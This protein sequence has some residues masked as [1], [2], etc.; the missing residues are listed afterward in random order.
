[1][2]IRIV[3][4]FLGVIAFVVSG[5]MIIPFVYSAAAKGRDAGVF[6]VSICAGFAASAALYLGG[7]GA[8]MSKMRTR[9]VMASVSFAWTVSSFI[10]A[11]PYW[12]EGAAP[13]YTDA[14]F[15][16]MS[17]FTT[18]GATIFESLD[19]LPRGLLLWR[20]LTHWLGGMGMIVLTLAL[21][22]VAGVGFQM[23]SAESPGMVH[24][25]IT[26]RLRQTAAALWGIYLGFTA[27]LTLLLYM[28]GFSFFEALNHS[29]ATISTGGFST[30]SSSVAYFGNARAEWMITLFMFMSGA[31]F[32]LYIHA[33]KGR[34][35]KNFLADP[36]FRFYSLFAAAASAAASAALYAGGRYESLAEAFRYGT[37]QAVSFITTTGFVSANYSAWPHFVQALLFVCLFPGA[38][39]G[40]TAGGIKQIRL[41]VACRHAARQISRTLSPRAVLV[42]PIGGAALEPSVVSSCLAF[43]GLYLAAFI[44]G[45]FAITIFEPDFMTAVS[46]AASALSNVGPAF[47]R[48]G[49]GGSF[50]GQAPAAKWI[51][52]FLMMIGRLEL[53]TVL[54]IFSREFRREGIIFSK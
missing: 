3:L 24:E 48:L 23:F 1:L 54:V 16:S 18:T 28:S 49:D 32:A 47:G 13:T 15:E 20:A 38:C 39:A 31:N 8:D 43:I 44:G 36:E 14:F 12:L 35:L 37:F 22:P 6:A 26:P 45:A 51:Y 53:Y 7:R 25:K 19:A 21:L 29:M 11:F 34:S 27:L 10:S 17:G 50:G 41:L 52:A 30:H 5:W 4:K 40:S 33:M 46:A 2:R 42:H 9:E